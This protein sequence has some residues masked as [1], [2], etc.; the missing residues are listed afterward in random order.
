MFGLRV[1]CLEFSLGLRVYTPQ[2]I[3]EPGKGPL[4]DNWPFQT[5]LCELDI[6]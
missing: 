3:L 1:S 5:C 6:V 4:V 2:N